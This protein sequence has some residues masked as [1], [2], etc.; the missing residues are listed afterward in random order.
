MAKLRSKTQS[1]DDSESAPPG[2]RVKKPENKTFGRK[3]PQLGRARY[4]GPKK[5]NDYGEKAANLLKLIKILTKDKNKS[6]DKVQN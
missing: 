3:S 2:P 1:S 6:S 5:K 4:Y